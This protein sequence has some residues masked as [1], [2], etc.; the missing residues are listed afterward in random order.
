[1]LSVL[2]LLS[3]WYCCLSEIGDHCDWWWFSDKE[4]GWKWWFSDNSAHFESKRVYETTHPYDFWFNNATL[5]YYQ[6]RLIDCDDDDDSNDD[7]NDDDDDVSDSDDDD[8]NTD[9][10]AD[11]LFFYLEACS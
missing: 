4:V 5:K 9:Y 6:Y 8:N 2:D 10:D 7:S 3:S 11:D 1:M